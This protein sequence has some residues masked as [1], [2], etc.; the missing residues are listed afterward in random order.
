METNSLTN[1][2]SSESSHAVKISNQRIPLISLVTPTLNSS[3]TLDRLY[4]S[5]YPQLNYIAEWIIV[6]SGSNDDTLEKILTYDTKKK[7]RIIRMERLGPYAAM[8]SG[9]MAARGQIIAILN[10]YDR[11]HKD[12]AKQVI[13][14]FCKNQS[15][16]VVYG[17][18][19]RLADEGGVLIGDESFC[20]YPR[21]RMNELHPSVFVRKSVYEIIGTFN[22]KYRINSDLD[23]LLRA[24]QASL[25]I[26]F[27]KNI[28]VDFYVG[29]L[30]CVELPRLS[31]V[32]KIHLRNNTPFGFLI[33]VS[34]RL[35]HAKML[36][37]L[38]NNGFIRLARIY[39]GCVS[40]L[41]K[42]SPRWYE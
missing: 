16:H 37:Y 14:S 10:S 38:E 17:R 32:V 13:E 30:S 21:F 19:R 8:N 34:T 25:N 3:A 33:F 12:T 5:I 18:I 40:L 4:S 36:S 22:T 7:A 28:V 24:K 31:D 6:D 27:D 26:Q 2:K 9:I 42:I 23:F 35:F 20:E 15:I 11:W 29:G 1:T 41:K 39:R